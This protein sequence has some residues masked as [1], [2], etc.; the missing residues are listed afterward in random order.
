MRV[1]S[2]DSPAPS[3]IPEARRDLAE[4]ETVARLGYPAGSV[5]SRKRM[6]HEARQNVLE[7]VHETLNEAAEIEAAKLARTDELSPSIN[8]AEA[9]PHL[10]EMLDVVKQLAGRDISRL[11]SGHLQSVKKGRDVS[12]ILRHRVF[13]FIESPAP[14]G[15]AG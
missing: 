3:L 15:P 14:R 8:F 6:S 12:T 13:G 2:E 4:P 9:V 7:Q 10:Q 5:E 1:A 11:S